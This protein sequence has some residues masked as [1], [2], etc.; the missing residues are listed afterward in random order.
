MY[1]KLEFLDVVALCS[2]LELNITILFSSDLINLISL[3]ILNSV[4]PSQV[5]KYNIALLQLRLLSV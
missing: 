1:L 4:P 3:S 2:I 5:F